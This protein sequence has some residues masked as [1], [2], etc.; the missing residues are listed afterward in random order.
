MEVL[1]LI[2]KEHYL[3]A[4]FEIIMTLLSKYV[5]LWQQRKMLKTD[6]NMKLDFF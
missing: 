2:L 4:Y 1:Y 3:T 5:N 6:D